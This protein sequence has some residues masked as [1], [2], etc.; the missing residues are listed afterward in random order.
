MLDNALKKHD[1]I[2]TLLSTRIAEETEM[3]QQRDIEERERKASE[4]RKKNLI[5]FYDKSSSVRDEWASK[6]QDMSDCVII[7]EEEFIKNMVKAEL[8][9]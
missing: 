3:L 6:R 7:K 5:E 9:Q 1:S 2:T 4:K 8:F